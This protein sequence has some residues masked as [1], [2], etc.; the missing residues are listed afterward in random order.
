M[1]LKMGDKKPMTSP[2]VPPELRL[3]GLDHL[4]RIYP[5]ALPFIARANPILEMPSPG[6]SRVESVELFLG[7]VVVLVNCSTPAL[8]ADGER[9][10]FR[11]VL[12]F[13][14]HA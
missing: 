10:G 8:E 1:G 3:G 14:H 13:I 5:R 2:L 4:W 9:L 12:G 11:V 7:K 6:G